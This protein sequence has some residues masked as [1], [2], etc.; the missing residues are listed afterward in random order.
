MWLAGETRGS[1]F[2]ATTAEKHQETS[3]PAGHTS[4]VLRLFIDGLEQRQDGQI[5]DVGP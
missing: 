3:Y 4:N 2:L 5:L 1:D